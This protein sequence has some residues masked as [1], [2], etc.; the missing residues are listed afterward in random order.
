MEK[1]KSP[2]TAVI[3]SFKEYALASEG[4]SCR[5]ET[6]TTVTKICV[7]IEAIPSTGGPDVVC[8]TE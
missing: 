2:Y 5:P 3:K 6:K 7:C 1:I 8:V 4:K